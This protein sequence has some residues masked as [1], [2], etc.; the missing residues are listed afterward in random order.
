MKKVHASISLLVGGMLCAASVQA[1]VTATS[2]N[3][4]YIDAPASVVQGAFQNNN[5]FYV[6]NEQQNYTLTSDLAVDW[7]S[8]DGGSLGNGSGGSISAGTRVNSYFLHFDP[9]S[10]AQ[11]VYGQIDFSEEILAVIYTPMNL[12]GSDGSLG[13]AGTD[14]ADKA[15]RGYE[16]HVDL[17]YSSLV[18]PNSLWIKNWANGDFTD[19]AR[20]I[21]AAPVP[22]PAALWLF[23]SGILAMLA[24]RRNKKAA[25]AAA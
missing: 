10:D 22:V 8:S 15:W 12:E 18:G 11:E 7:L 5:E 21:T 3:A 4:N 16:S 6:F 25:V 14:Y 20:V 2:D 1:G 17:D 13:A 9:S 19:Q 24:V 23:G